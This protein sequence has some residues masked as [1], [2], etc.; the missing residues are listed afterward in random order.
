MDAQDVVERAGEG[1]EGGAPASAGVEAGVVLWQ[2]DLL[3]EAVGLTM[4]AMPASLSSWGRRFWQGAEHA[5]RA[6]ELASGESGINSMPSCARARP[7]GRGVL[8]TL[9]PALGRPVVAGAV[10]AVEQQWPLAQIASDTPQWKLD[11]VPVFATKK[12]E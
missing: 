3:E 6:P 2:E 1:D 7:M 4:S 10:P 9:P 8:V 5:L 11:M 12:A